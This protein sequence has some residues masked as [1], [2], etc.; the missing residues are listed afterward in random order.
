MVVNAVATAINIVASIITGAIGVFSGLINFINAVFLG[1]WSAAWNAV[2]SIFSSVF[3][4]IK[5][6]ASN[7]LGGITNTISNIASSI[8]S[9][10]GL[11]GFGG[12]PVAHN[13]QG[14]IYN[15]G[16]FLTTFAEDGPEAAIPL[17]GSR[18][19]IGLWQKAGEILGIGQGNGGNTSTGSFSRGDSYDSAPPIT[20]SLN[21]YGNADADSV[22][23]AVEKAARSAQESFAEQMA[24]FRREER[25]LAYE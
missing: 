10:T 18:R 5:N 21:F 19:A 3:N 4:T 14:G 9:I 8:G 13:A 6:I 23:G 2:L 12:A 16:A 17:D 7:I 22:R 1:N 24:R 20:I 25:R 15:K 11:T